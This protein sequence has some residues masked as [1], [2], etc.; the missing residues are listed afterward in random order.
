MTSNSQN[1]SLVLV[2]LIRWGST[3]LGK[4]FSPEKHVN[5][6]QTQMRESLAIINKVMDTLQIELVLKNCH[7]PFK[8]Q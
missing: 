8:F 1:F 6:G 4:V 3:K 2:E 5:S 7:F